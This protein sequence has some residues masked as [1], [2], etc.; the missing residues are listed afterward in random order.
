MHLKLYNYRKFI[1]QFT[2]TDNKYI[3]LDENYDVIGVDIRFS[4][5]N[6]I[7]DRILKTLDFLYRNALYSGYLEPKTKQQV[8]NVEALKG[9]YKAKKL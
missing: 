5:R 6:L 8:A 2:V 1:T 9:L 7:S 3:Q 4:K